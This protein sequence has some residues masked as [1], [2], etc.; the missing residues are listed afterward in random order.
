MS[1]GLSPQLQCTSIPVPSTAISMVFSAA[2]YTQT[3]TN[4]RGGRRSGSECPP[5]LRGIATTAELDLHRPK[6]PGLPRQITGGQDNRTTTRTTAAGHPWGPS[7]HAPPLTTH[8]HTK[9]TAH[10][11]NSRLR[12]GTTKH[13]HSPSGPARDP[14]YAHLSGL[15]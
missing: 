5:T 14:E 3:D 10:W 2:S 11:P 7:A 12:R 6:P 15:T 4:R 8:R 13:T 9:H 1:T